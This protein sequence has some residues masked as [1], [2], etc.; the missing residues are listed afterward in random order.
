LVNL[1]FQVKDDDF[2]KDI[3]SEFY[4]KYE[5]EPVLKRQKIVKKEAF[6]EA[7]NEFSTKPLYAL[8]PLKKNRFLLSLS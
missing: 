8:Y 2:G 4:L 1:L 6:L 7:I 3:E 5:H